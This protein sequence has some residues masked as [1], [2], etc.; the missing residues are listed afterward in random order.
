VTDAQ[1]S[2][3]VADPTRPLRILQL[4]THYRQ[5]GGEDHVVRTEARLLRRAGHEVLTC[6]TSNPEGARAASVFASAPYNPNAAA[7]V[8]RVAERF[9]PDVAHVHNTWFAMS[10]AVLSALRK[11]GVPVVQ[12]LHNYRLL[13]AAATLYRDGAPCVDCVGTHPWHAV[14]HRCYRG[15]A[16]QSAI[17]AAT[18]ALHARR[19]TWHRDVDHYLALTDFGRRRFIDGGFPAD[20]IT[21]KSNSVDD[22]GGRPAPPSRGRDVVFLGRLS[23]EKG[24]LTLLEAWRRSTARDLRLR[25]VGVGPLEPEL[26]RFAPASVDIVGSLPRERIDVLLLAARAL[27]FP[28]TWFEGQGL[29][30]LEAAAAGL[31]V[32]H[33]DLGVMSELFAPGSE[34]LLVPPGDA[35]AL[36]AKLEQL[37]DDDFVDRA[38]S[39]TRQRFEERYTHERALE[40]LLKT[41]RSVLR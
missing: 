40:R 29:V 32:L 39:L 38:G 12:T 23:E 7:R 3:A 35:D 10:P 24:V 5:A 15:S 28:S 21:V 22:P 2:S 27:V 17:A 9:R 25:I 8:A 6:T 13:C 41:Y 11:V 4:H 37:T 30:A 14:R 26:R 20:R 31:P 36:A 19:G 16:P 34:D 18:M 33:S 1:A